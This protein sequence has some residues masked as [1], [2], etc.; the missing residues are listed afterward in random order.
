MKLGP[1]KVIRIHDPA[2]GLKAILVIDNVAAGPAIG[3]CRMAVDVSLDECARPSLHYGNLKQAH[4]QAKQWST[5][6]SSPPQI[7][8]DRL[9]SYGVVHRGV[10]E[11]ERR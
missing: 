6:C 8:T 10:V 1:E 3:G 4:T 7:V 11:T 5:T 2:T 9:S